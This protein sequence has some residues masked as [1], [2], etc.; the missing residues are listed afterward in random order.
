VY[1][2]TTMARFRLGSVHYRDSMIQ[3]HELMRPF[4]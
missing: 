2:P 4:R 1:S 3:L